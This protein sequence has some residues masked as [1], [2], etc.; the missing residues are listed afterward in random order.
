MK[1]L[2]HVLF[3]IFIVGLLTFVFGRSYYEFYESFYFVCMLL[4][5]V[6]GTTYFFNYFLVPRYLLKKKYFKF[7]LYS[8]YLL[9]ISLNLEMYVM[10]ATFIIMAEYKYANMNPLTTDV[11]ILTVTLYLVVFG[12]SFV[13][14]VR[15][16]FHNQEF[17]R[18]YEDKLEK[19]Q[20]S[21]LV[22]KENRK[23]VP[24]PLDDIT[25]IESLGDYVKIQ[26]KQD[27]TILTKEK[28]STLH[29]NLPEDFIR[30]HRSI[31][32]NKNFLTSFNK[33]FVFISETQLPISRSYKKEVLSVMNI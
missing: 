2:K 31:I 20:Q 14:L 15:F 29:S 11:F 9:I 26:T 6:L 30:I 17:I 4:P 24:I 21:H 10:T 19:S 28:I 16:Y 25:Y 12:L 8:T 18:E 1:V 3:W 5:V 7:I 33:E 13:R 27:R 23:N 22:V 32:V